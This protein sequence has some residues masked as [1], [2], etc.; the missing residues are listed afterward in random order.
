MDEL[1][2]V[3]IPVTRAA[4]EA[5]SDEARRQRI[6]R[7]VSRLVRPASLDEDPLAALIAETKASARA[8]G[9]TDE[10]IDAD[11]AAWNAERRL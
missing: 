8:G 5:L 7:L 4:A 2:M 6:G 1:V 3:Q 10:E 9:L 11:L